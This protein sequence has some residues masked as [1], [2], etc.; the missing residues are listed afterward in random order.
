MDV[1]V[2]EVTVCS[3]QLVFCLLLFRLCSLHFSSNQDDGSDDDLEDIPPPQSDEDTSEKLEEA[4]LDD[5][6]KVTIPRRRLA[7]WCNDIFFAMA[8]HDCYVRLYVGKK[9]MVKIFIGCVKSL[10]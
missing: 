4:D 1:V 2:L 3:H 9:P 7:R 6:V 10:V 5:F 8:V